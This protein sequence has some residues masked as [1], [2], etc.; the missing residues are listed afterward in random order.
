[1][2]AQKTIPPYQLDTLLSGYKKP[3]DLIDKNGF[4][5]PQLPRKWN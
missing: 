1:M 3:E 4:I 5:S 2:T